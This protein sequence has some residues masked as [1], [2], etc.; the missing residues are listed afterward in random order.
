MKKLVLG[1]GALAVLAVAT[2]CINSASADDKK[3]LSIKDVMKQAH[4]PPA[5]SLRTKVVKG[6]A[7]DEEKKKLVTL[8]EALAKTQPP[9]GSKEAWA[10]KTKQILTVAK[11]VAAGKEGAEKRLGRATGC[12]GCHR[13]FKPE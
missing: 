3:E 1:M 7:S 13:I 10:K 6:E 12:G 9:K 4:V 11:A 5:S 8:Y 2:L